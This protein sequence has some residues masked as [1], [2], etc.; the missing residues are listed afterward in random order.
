MKRLICG[1]FNVI[2]PYLAVK[3]FFYSRP[4][5]ILT[6]FASIIRIQKCQEEANPLEKGVRQPIYQD[7]CESLSLH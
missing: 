1:H 6:I 5:N 4:G 3:D 7:D 2:T